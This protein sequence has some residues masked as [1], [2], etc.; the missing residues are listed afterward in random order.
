MAFLEHI[1]LSKIGIFEAKMIQLYQGE[2]LR[3]RPLRTASPFSSSQ[4]YLTNHTHML[5]SIEEEKERRNT[6]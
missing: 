1:K 5:R 3:P 2:S 6:S 4:F